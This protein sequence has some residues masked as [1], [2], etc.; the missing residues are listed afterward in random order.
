[1]GQQKPSE[2]LAEILRICP[3][4]KENSDHFNCLP[5][6]AAGGSCVVCCQERTKPTRLRSGRTDQFWAQNAQHHQ[7]TVAAVLTNQEASD[8]A[9][10]LCSLPL[11]DKRPE[12]R[13][14]GGSQ[15]QGCPKRGAGLLTAASSGLVGYKRRGSPA[16]LAARR[17]YV[18]H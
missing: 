7:D 10:Q 9:V 17:R 4:E 3:R 14:H 16:Q 1:M 5:A 2:L 6:E 8:G 12:N 11:V 18:A 15:C 13:Q